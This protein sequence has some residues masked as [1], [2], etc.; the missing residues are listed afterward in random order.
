M[1]VSGGST[2]SEPAYQVI[3]RR[4]ACR[5]TCKY[6]H[7][8]VGCRARLEHVLVLADWLL[9]LRRFV[10][11]LSVYFDFELSTLVPLMISG[12]DRSRSG[13]CQ[14]PCAIAAAV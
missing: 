10:Q 12:V 9:R 14:E 13:A 8:H 4:I 6:V 2:E 5:G 11:R 3:P 1:R 7:V